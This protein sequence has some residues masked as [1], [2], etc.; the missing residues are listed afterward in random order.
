MRTG[1]DSGVSTAGRLQARLAGAERGPLR[2]LAGFAGRRFPEGR[3]LLMCADPGEVTIS[4][5]GRRL[6]ITRQ[7]ASK[8]IA[9]LRERGYGR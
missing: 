2:G 9:A 6:A 1:N 7:G 3:V 4:D 8:V 5:I